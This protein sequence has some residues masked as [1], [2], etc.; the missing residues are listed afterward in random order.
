MYAIY[1]KPRKR[2]HFLFWCCYWNIKTE[3][4]RLHAIFLSFS[5]A[6]GFFYAV[7]C[8]FVV[9]G[10]VVDIMLSG[11]FFLNNKKIHTRRGK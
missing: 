6:F 7:L 9:D 3:L 11:V 4:N 2:P 8:T 1:L 5:P 10:V